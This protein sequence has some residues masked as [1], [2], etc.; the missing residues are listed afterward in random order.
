MSINTMPIYEY[1]C[2][3]CAHQF[4]LI[5]LPASPVPAC[6]ECQSQ[7]LEQLLSAFAVSSADTRHASLQAARRK[8]VA[9]S[10]SR[11]KKVADEEYT[12]KVMEEHGEEPPKKPVL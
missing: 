8:S 5:V 2:R 11:D 6:P 4:E 3:G 10:Q 1:Q 9:S 12:L 7:D